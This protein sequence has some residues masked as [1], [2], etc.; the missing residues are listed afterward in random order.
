MTLFRFQSYR[1]SDITKA[2]FR[3]RIFRMHIAILGAG[4]VGA[5]LA[6][7]W[8]HAGHEVTL[9]LRDPQRY[10]TLLAETG[11]AAAPLAEAAAKADIVVIALPWPV[12]E[13]ALADIGDLGG[14]IVID[15]MNPLV[16]RPHGP[17]LAIG[18]HT[19]AGEMVAGWLPSARVVKTL[20]QCG[21][22][23]MAENAAMQARPVMFMASDYAD[24]KTVVAG[25]LN[26]LGFEPLDAGDLTKARLLEPMA[27]V[28]INQALMRGKGRDWAFAAIPNPKG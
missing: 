12:A 19:S 27:M 28:W 3:Q 22:N 18:H 6:R 21:A 1:V 17:E 15:T 16:R 26:E 24:A 4:N 5:A 9:G 10:S 7:G 23:I 8:R 2:A 25:L 13:Q 11:A 20:N 14:K